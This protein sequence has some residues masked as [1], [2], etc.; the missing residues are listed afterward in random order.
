MGVNW[1]DDFEDNCRN[2]DIYILAHIKKYVKG[3]AKNK[4]NFLL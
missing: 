3:I 2:I 1:L 4:E